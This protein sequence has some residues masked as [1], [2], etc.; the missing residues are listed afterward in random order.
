MPAAK[1]KIDQQI[2][3]GRYLIMI[4]GCNDCH[5]PGFDV[6]G[7]KMPESE[8]LTGSSMGFKGPW[9]T[10]YPLNLRML[11]NSMTED[12]WVEYARSTKGA[13]PMP[14]W[15][16]HTMS[17]SDLSAIYKFVK[18][19]G[20]KGEA[21]PAIVLPNETPKTPYILFEPVFPSK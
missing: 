3:Q 14:W 15:A 18:S 16:L 1:Q 10:S 2:A 7:G 21:A 6:S 11:I 12:S 17:K 19:L 9:G 4:G 8:W 13:P 20:V 5:T